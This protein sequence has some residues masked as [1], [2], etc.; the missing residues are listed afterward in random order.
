V[1]TQKSSKKNFFLE[2]LS[3][4]ALRALLLGYLMYDMISSIRP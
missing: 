3:N 4:L 2:P 1:K